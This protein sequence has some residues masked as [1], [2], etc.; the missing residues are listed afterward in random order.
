MQLSN[1]ISNSVVSNFYVYPTTVKTNGHQTLT[2]LTRSDYGGCLFCYYYCF[3]SK[4]DRD[5]RW[6][7]LRLTSAQLVTDFVFSF[8]VRRI[9][10]T[11]E[12]SD[13]HYR[14][15]SEIFIC[16]KEGS[17]TSKIYVFILQFVVLFFQ[18]IDSTVAR[19]FSKKTVWNIRCNLFH[20]TFDDQLLSLTYGFVF[21]L[22]FAVPNTLKMSLII[23]SLTSP[24]A[25]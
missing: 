1:V 20:K 9:V 11:Y 21:L 15:E 5:Y 17:H 18:P 7:Y 4:H 22:F 23:Y 25:G 14:R 8:Y 12:I 2:R 6:E 10:P 24:T 3:L 13:S 19:L 16:L